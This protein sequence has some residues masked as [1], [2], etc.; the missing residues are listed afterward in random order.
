MKRKRKKIPKAPH[1][2]IPEAPYKNFFWPTIPIR[3]QA[4]CPQASRSCKPDGWP[5]GNPKWTKQQA[6]QETVPYNDIEEATSDD[7]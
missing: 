2:K 3:Q 5:K 7:K 6:I 4:T 1:K